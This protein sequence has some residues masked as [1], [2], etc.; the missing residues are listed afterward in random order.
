[1]TDEKK[2]WKRCPS[3]KWRVWN[4]PIDWHAHLELCPAKLEKQL[5]ELR[6]EF[7]ALQ[8]EALKP[9]PAPAPPA[10]DF[11]AIEEPDEEDDPEEAGIFDA[12]TTPAPVPPA[13]DEYDPEDDEDDEPT[14]ISRGIMR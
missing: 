12:V 8:R 10:V 9:L 6:R 4:D 2:P 1:M 14:P 5:G 11:G 7:A 3:C 13:I